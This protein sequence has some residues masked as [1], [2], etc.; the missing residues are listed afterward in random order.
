[1]KNED[2][3]K[4]FNPNDWFFC[5]NGKLPQCLFSLSGER[6]TRTRNKITEI[7]DAMSRDQ[8]M[9]ARNNA[10]EDEGKA[11]RTTKKATGKGATT[12]KAII[13]LGYN[14]VFR[15]TDCWSWSDDGEEWYVGMWE[16][17]I[18]S[19]FTN[20]PPI[21][22][23]A[24]QKDALPKAARS[25]GRR[26]SRQAI[27][28]WERIISATLFWGKAPFILGNSYAFLLFEEPFL[29]YFWFFLSSGKD[30]LT[31]AAPKSR[32]VVLVK[33]NAM[34]ISGIGE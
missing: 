33:M 8:R 20:S 18:D 25:N 21:F 4:A 13:D 2:K 28:L 23:N 27:G 10:K 32:N 30:Q 11:K 9:E 29:H 17:E 34:H 22:R 31:A 3:G 5:T 12:L 19:Q 7:N 24:L 15:M 14:E 1:M 16:R 6:T 26:E